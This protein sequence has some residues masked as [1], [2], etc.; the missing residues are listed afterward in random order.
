MSHFL[1]F[2]GSDPT[3]LVN[4]FTGIN[5]FEDALVG[6]LQILKQCLYKLFDDGKQI[7]ALLAVDR[8]TISAS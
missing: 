1:S 7:Q 5:S 8:R 6:K 4:H 2:Q 3:T